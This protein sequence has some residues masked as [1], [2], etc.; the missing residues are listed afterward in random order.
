LNK[1]HI[2][3]LLVII[4]MIVTI[5]LYRL[6]TI[7][8]TSV[9][10]ADDKLIASDGLGA[11]QP[12]IQGV[13]I[14]IG[15]LVGEILTMDLNRSSRLVYVN[16]DNAHWK[17]V[18]LVDMPF[19]LS[20]KSYRMVLLLSARNKANIFKMDVGEKLMPPDL[21]IIIY[22]YDPNT[23]ALACIDT[24]YP[25]KGDFMYGSI[26]IKITAPE[27]PLPLSDDGH[28]QLT[29]TNEYTWVL[30]IDGWFASFHRSYRGDFLKYYVRLSLVLTISRKSVI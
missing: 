8:I 16:F 22:F 12:N 7:I 24:I 27:P 4:V 15:E 14:G 9:L 11:Y 13:Y 19:R 3:V 28:I 25:F 1:K 6:H 21:F 23:G 5:L 18:N 29:K 26:H 20:S 30:D 10:I 2:L 17:D